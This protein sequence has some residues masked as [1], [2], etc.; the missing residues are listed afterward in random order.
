MNS[1]RDGGDM[2]DDGISQNVTASHSRDHQQTSDGGQPSASGTIVVRRATVSPSVQV[3]MEKYALELNEWNRWFSFDGIMQR[4]SPLDARMDNTAYM[5]LDHP[6]HAVASSFKHL[7]NADVKMLAKLHHALPHGQPRKEA[8]LDAL[9]K[10]IC[11][12]ECHTVYLVFKRRERPRTSQPWRNLSSVFTW[13][14][15]PLYNDTSDV[16]SSTASM[17]TSESRYRITDNTT[18]KTPCLIDTPRGGERQVYRLRNDTYPEVPNTVGPATL[19]LPTAKTYEAQESRPVHTED[20]RHL[21]PLTEAQILRITKE[22]QREMSLE[23]FLRMPCAVCSALKSKKELKRKHAST[24]NLSL[25]RNDEIPENLQPSTYNLEAY[26]RA[27]LDPHGLEDRQQAGW[28]NIC[29]T[30][31]TDLSGARMPKFALCNWLYYAREHIPPQVRDAFATM[32]VFEKALIS[33]VRTNSLL[34][35]FSGIDDDPTG[36]PV[37]RKNRHIKGNIISTPL[38]TARVSAVLP[39][40][41]SDIADTICALIVSSSPPTKTTIDNLKP[42]LV[43]KSR[44][45]L[46]IDFLIANNPLY[47]KSQTFGG[48]SSEN[49]EQLFSGAHDEGVPAAVTIGHIPINRA[50]ESLTEDYTGRLDGIEGLFMENVAYTSGDH[51]AQSFRDMTF[52]A[53]ERCKEGKPFLHARSGS[54]PVPD[55]QNP[56]WLSW[57]HPDAD[58]FGLG[59]FHHP[60]RQRTIGMEQQLKHLLNVR[61]PFFENDPEL[62]FDV[63]NVIRKGAVNTNLRFSVPYPVYAKTVDMITALNKDDITAL[64]HKFQRNPNYEPSSQTELEVVRAMTA[65][66]PIARNVPGT[67]SQKI[68]MRNEIRAMIGQRGSPT[69]FVTLNPCDYY[70]PIVSVLASRLSNP[71]SIASIQRIDT[72]ARARMAV[73][74]PAACAQFFDAMMNAFIRI[75]LRCNRRGK[76]PGIFGTCEAYYGTV[77]T[78]GRGS[79]HCHLLIWLKDHLPPEMLAEKLRT[80]NEY[81]EALRTW[82]DS[83]VESGFVGSKAI[84]NN[85]PMGE[86]KEHRK[87]EGQHPVA[88]TEPKATDHPPSSFFKER[89][90]YID[91]LLTKVNWHVHTGSCWKYLKPGEARSPEN[92]RFGMEGTTSNATEVDTN[93]GTINLKRV[94][95][96]MT[97]YNPTVTFLMKCNTDIKFIGSG[98]DAKA[99]MYYVTDYITKAPLSMHAGLTAL[100]YAIRQAEAKGVMGENAARGEAVDRRAITIAINSMLGH[101]EVSHPQV[102]S[103]IFGG[104]EH[105]TNES[106]QAINWAEVLRF[107]SAV[108]EPADGE[109]KPAEIAPT[110]EKDEESE[111]LDKLHVLLTNDGSRFHASNL[112]LDYIFRPNTEPYDT[113]GLYNHIART[114]RVSLKLSPNANAKAAPDARRFSSVAHPQHSTHVLGIRRTPAV[115]VLLGP[116]IP[117]RDGSDAERE[118]WAKN[119][120]ILFFPWRRAKDLTL[121]TGMTWWTAISARIPELSDPDRA[122]LNNMALV[123]EGRQARDQRP[124]NKKRGVNAEALVDIEQIPNLEETVGTE[125]LN[126]Y[127]IA[128]QEANEEGTLSNPV[129]KT[130]AYIDGLLGPNSS[131]ALQSC[132]PFKHRHSTTQADIDVHM[133]DETELTETILAKQKRYMAKSRYRS[134]STPDKPRKGVKGKKKLLQAKPTADVMTL[135]E[136][137]IN[138]QRTQVANRSKAAKLEEIRGLT[139]I[140]EQHRAFT[141]ITEHII[142]GGPQLLMYI[143]GEG[144][145]G[146]SHLLESIQI[147]FGQ[148]QRETELRI[149]AYTGIA[150]SLIGGSTLHSL[151]AM[152]SQHKQPSALV[153]RLVQEWKGVTYFFV[154]EVS[155][156]SAQFL[157]GVSSRLQMGKSDH[158]EA[159]T[160]LFGGV[161]MIFLGDFYQLAPPNQ[162]PLY[163][164]RLVRNPTFLEARDNAGIDS[165][166]GAYLWRQLNEVVILRHSKRHENDQ[167]LGRLLTLIRNRQCI[168]K[169]ER[170]VKIDGKTVVEHIRERDLAHVAHVDP[171]S[172]LSFQDAPVIVGTRIVR[173]LMNSTLLASHSDRIRSEAHIYYSVDAIKGIRARE[174]ACSVLW[175]LPSTTTKDSFGQLPMFVGMRVMITENVSVT[176]KVANGS[177]GTIERIKYTITEGKRYADVVYVKVKAKNTT[178]H[179]PGL[180]PGV[181]PIFPTSTSIV[182]TTRLG[183]SVSK[184]FTRSQIPIVPA[185]SYTDYKSQGRTLKRAIVDLASAKSQGVYVMLSRVTTLKGLLVLRWFP[186]NKI[187]QEMSGELRDEINRLDELD[188]ACLKR[189]ARSGLTSE[190]SERQ[191]QGSINKEKE[192]EDAQGDQT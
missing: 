111:A 45:K 87:T 34:C 67:V 51:S 158:S 108:S 58:P 169:T 16:E 4:A 54:T 56:S 147:F 150:A 190:T 29:K 151:L 93:T 112:L 76:S 128:L 35:R 154:D 28:M 181:V 41:P 32:S 92:C 1:I 98:L 188:R 64:R 184:S 113:M 36:D 180:P 161:N 94:N 137:G 136:D 102:M 125:Q 89:N 117:R 65:V 144:G 148:I 179:A 95:P 53:M 8:I 40:S 23:S 156:V 20:V 143:G 50:L 31:S 167:L 73:K 26:G 172:L 81:G 59:G 22:W 49:L 131:S 139:T 162:S 38:N 110:S 84:Y 75:V 91:E 80:S 132:F 187:L 145:T 183:Q 88:K 77:E 10:H 135:R 43:R 104:G 12:L 122:V 178:I 118:E 174:P 69:L 152:G 63:Y 177:E 83:V 37:S 101:Q 149:G 74:H 55:I 105:Y 103:Y 14:Q 61:D 27:L 116:R 60:K 115:P 168:D 21:K 18:S 96:R 138:L 114:R 186:E 146:K 140:P 71:E 9:K 123:A 82:L 3:T 127:A 134:K 99:F 120:R 70:N 133:D 48:F 106:F 57:A 182:Y 6:L 42:I 155:M 39:P 7:T 153:K 72:T 66:A 47:K 185:Y 2:R 173:D 25:L 78:Q 44:V 129:S 85:N 175:S 163:A 17:A 90:E 121:P 100:S 24:L 11:A 52:V 165:V 62:A 166:T 86:D 176:H 46:L 79:L 189:T 157:A 192:R 141:I 124:R 142:R 15:A 159:S 130:A 30:C 119:M 5:I 68:T 33:R 171:S 13:T 164:Y 191:S 126:V 170:Q 107:V 19:P 160:K 109:D 97:H